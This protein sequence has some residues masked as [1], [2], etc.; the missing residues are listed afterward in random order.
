L[1]I[2]ISHISE[3]ASIVDVFKDWIESTFLGQ[4]EVFASRDKEDLPLGNN[5]INEIDRT[6]DSSVAFLVLCSPASLKRPWINFET[7]WGWI[8]GVPI[9]PICHSGQKKD[10]LPPRISTF[11]SLEIDSAGFVSVLFSRLAKHL[12][13]DKFPR[14]DQDAMLREISAAIHAVA[15]R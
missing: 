2:F 13:F 3:E 4:C 5:W 8:K 6:L 7:G 11:E 1:N 12:G 9:I 15:E 14:I 10:A